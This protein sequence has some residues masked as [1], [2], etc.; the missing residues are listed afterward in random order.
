MKTLFNSCPLFLIHKRKL[1]SLFVSLRKRKEAVAFLFDD[2][3]VIVN[4]VKFFAAIL[5]TYSKT[6]MYFCLVEIRILFIY[7]FIYLFYGDIPNNGDIHQCFTT[8]KTSLEPHIWKCPQYNKL[9]TSSQCN[10]RS[11]KSGFVVTFPAN[12]DWSIAVG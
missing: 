5:S 6:V 3:I 2:F 9:Q 8:R 11:V 10:C 12:A 7:S 1:H 4:I